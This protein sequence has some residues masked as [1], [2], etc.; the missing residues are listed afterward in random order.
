M[1]NQTNNVSDVIL[2]F[3]GLIAAQKAFQE[4]MN[5]SLE[6]IQ[7]TSISIKTEMGEK[8]SEKIELFRPLFREAIE[9]SNFLMLRNEGLSNDLLEVVHEV[10][11]SRAREEKLGL[12][13][14]QRFPTVSIA[15]AN[16]ITLKRG[17]DIMTE[18]L[19]QLTAE[20][21]WALL[22]DETPLGHW[23]ARLE[24]LSERYIKG[25][26]TDERF[27]ML[28]KDLTN[29]AIRASK[30]VGL[31]TQL[32]RPSRAAAQKSFASFEKDTPFPTFSK[33]VQ[34]HAEKMKVSTKDL[35]RNTT[36][37]RDTEQAL[38]QLKA[39]EKTRQQ[40]NWFPALKEN[41]EAAIFSEMDKQHQ[42]LQSFLSA[43]QWTLEQKQHFEQ[44]AARLQVTQN[45]LTEMKNKFGRG[46][47]DISTMEKQLER[48]EALPSSETI[49]VDLQKIKDSAA[50]LHHGRGPWRQEMTRI[51]KQLRQNK[52]LFQKKQK[53]ESAGSSDGTALLTTL[54]LYN[55]ITD[56]P[57]HA[58]T[59]QHILGPQAKEILPMDTPSNLQSINPMPSLDQAS[60]SPQNFNLNFDEIDNTISNITLALASNMTDVKSFSPSPSSGAEKSGDS[61]C[62][63]CGGCSG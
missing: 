48:L 4:E 58:G 63:N 25:D 33:K 54:L 55:L 15:E 45:T 52:Q 1:S 14:K 56:N 16:I 35:S 17:E 5:Q 26:L 59:S 24:T 47:A 11:L 21:P 28:C 50:N 60:L 30:P 20:A 39:F 18:K 29:E 8:V 22:K 31:L 6:E 49:D 34:T 43:E 51:S 37:L 38:T 41:L 10:Y 27:R 13:L 23:M 40:D 53:N 36:A 44:W 32:F 12:L 46:A 19:S 62:S 7:A 61:S 2:A 3:G 9:K 57:A 42:R